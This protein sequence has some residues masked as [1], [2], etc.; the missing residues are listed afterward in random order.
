MSRLTIRQKLLAL[1]AVAI[2]SL[3]AVN[4]F[5]FQQT[6]RLYA[7]LE[8]FQKNSALLVETIDSARDAQVHFKIQVQEWKD[9]LLRGR[10]QADFDKHLKGFGEQELAVREQLEQARA[11]ASQLGFAEGLGIERVQAA[12]A[13]LGAAYRDAL[14]HYDRSAENPAGTV[15][16]MVKGIDREPTTYIDN[17]VA[18]VQEQ[19]AKLSAQGAARAQATYAAIKLWMSIITVVS[20]VVTGLVALLIMRSVTGPVRSLQDTMLGIAASGDLSQRAKVE[21]G[22]EIAQMGQAFNQMVGHFQR[23]IGQVL[24]SSH[25]VDQAAGELSGSSAQLAVVSDTQASA[26]SGSAAA[27]EELTVA[28]VSVSDTASEAHSLSQAC[29]GDTLHGQEQVTRLVGEI[30]SIQRNIGGI[31]ESVDAF[32]DNTRAITSIAAEVREIA[33]QTNLLA[34]NAAIEAARAGESGRGFAVVADSVRELA[35]KSGGSAAEIHSITSTLM[36]QS[37]TLRGAVEAGQQAV[38][39]SVGLAGTVEDAIRQA[40]AS[41]HKVSGEVDE[42]ASAI[43]QQKAAST[44]IAQNM[45]KISSMVEETTSAVH[46]VS[47][48]ARDLRGLSGSLS[49]AVSGFRI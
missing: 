46:Q 17:L 22:D 12:F 38:Q 11:A 48:A 28:M 40:Q 45:E 34:L 32:L 14:S 24:Q 31:A 36:Q 47:G 3:V 19:A 33:D 30:R 43:T 39:T 6:A 16:A 7:D 44:E 35:A 4:L 23:L 2:V 1:W 8:R 10:E 29:V 21:G 15:D 42:I 13:K 5:A 49:D 41:V 20:L 26:V 25:Q 27:V 37:A 9:I 18:A